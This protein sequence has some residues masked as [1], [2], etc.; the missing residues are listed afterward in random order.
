MRGAALGEPL[1]R[2]WWT[3]VPSG[4]TGDLDAE[5]VTL[6]TLQAP[7]AWEELRAT[8]RL[9]SRE[10]H[11][12]PGY[13]PAYRW[14]RSRMEALGRVGPDDGDGMVWFWSRVPRSTLREEYRLSARARG[15]EVMITARVPA[16]RVLHSC[17]QTW[18][19]VLNRGLEVP[20]LPG[21]TDEAWSTRF[22]TVIADW[23]ERT[24]PWRSVPVESWPRHLRR[25]M[26]DSWEWIFRP[27]HHHRVSHVQATVATLRAEDVVRAVRVR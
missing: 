5:H 16:A 23:D 9:T 15:G 7:E 17:F 3:G 26:E 18:H 1:R 13:R 6:V 8:G 2:R 24:D 22:D 12:D 20:L 10:E 14:L 21:E 25:E 4:L 11:V 19:V 27:D